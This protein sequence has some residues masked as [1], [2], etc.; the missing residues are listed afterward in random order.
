MKDAECRT[1]TRTRPTAGRS[2]IHHSSF[3]ILHSDRRRRAF[4]LLELILVMLIL[5][6]IVA[7]I[8]PEM[9]N[10]GRNRRAGDCAGQIVAVAHWARTR[11][12]ADGVPYR[13]NVD[14]QQGTYWLTM[15]QPSGAD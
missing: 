13:L 2:S 7:M 14:P 1:K 11:A 10:F 8:V 6:I 5:A 9:S 12:I 4:S 15:Q 3:I